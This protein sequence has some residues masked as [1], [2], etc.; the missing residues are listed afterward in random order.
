MKTEL[1]IDL[2]VP[3]PATTAGVLLEFEKENKQCKE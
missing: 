3:P 2:E 1:E